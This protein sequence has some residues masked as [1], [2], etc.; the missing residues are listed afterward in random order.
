MCGQRRAN[1]VEIG[2]ALEIGSRQH[3]KQ[4]R[5]VHAA[6]IAAERHLAQVRH[7]A[8]T[9]FVQDFARLRVRGGVDLGRLAGG[10]MPSTPRAIEGSIQSVSSAVMIP[11]RPKTA[12]NQ[13][14]PA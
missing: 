5:C 9:G 6:V 7:L 8:V 12:L 13:G 2:G 11:S 10:E 4:R 3:D 14:I 1:G